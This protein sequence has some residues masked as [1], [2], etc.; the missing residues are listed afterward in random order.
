MLVR[1]DGR[2]FMH[3]HPL[4][5]GSTAAQERLQR[6]EAGDTA[7]HG[8]AQP[9]MDMSTMHATALPGDVR[10]PVAFP[11]AGTYRVFVQLRRTT[12]EIVTAALDISIPESSAR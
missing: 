7:M 3:L 10:F 2:V 4:G 11:S 8:D 5:T 9:Q 1:T 12:G 6:R